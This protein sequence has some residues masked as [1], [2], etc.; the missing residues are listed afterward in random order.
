MSYKKCTLFIILA[1]AISAFAQDSDSW[2]DSRN[3][4]TD[5]GSNYDTETNFTIIDEPQLAQFAYMVNSG[6]NFEGKTV[7]LER[8]LSNMGL[9]YWDPIGKSGSCFSGVFEGNNHTISYVYVDKP[10]ADTVGLFGCVSRPENSTT[11]ISVKNI[12]PCRIAISRVK[13]MLGEL[14][15]LSVIR[16]H[17]ITF[18]LRATM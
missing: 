13:T 2:S 11:S 16:A 10:S 17:M 8:D 14:L 9:H 7:T 15:G 3:R 12:T 18:S 6:K 5:W 1:L 4:N